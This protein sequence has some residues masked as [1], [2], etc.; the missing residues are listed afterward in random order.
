MLI[1]IVF[2]KEAIAKKL[3]PLY[4]ILS[5]GLPLVVTVWFSFV[6]YLGYD[7]ETTPGWCGI[8]GSKLITE[9]NSTHKEKLVFPVI[10]GYT[11]FVYVAFLLLPIMYI[12]IRCHIKILVSLKTQLL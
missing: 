7:P 11:G 5:W 8:I 1:I 10:L 6:G 3:L 4:Y 12:V 9:G 2:Q